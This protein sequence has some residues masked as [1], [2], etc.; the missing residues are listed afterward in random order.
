MNC[1]NRESTD[2]ARLEMIYDQGTASGSYSGGG[3]MVGHV[4]GQWGVGVS[5]QSGGTFR[6]SNLARQ[7]AP[8]SPPSNT[9]R[10]LSFVVFCVIAFPIIQGTNKLILILHQY[11][12]RDIAEY[13]EYACWGLAMI[14]ILVLPG[15]ISCL[16]V[17][18]ANRKSYQEYEKK[19]DIW[20]R[21][22]LCFR[23]GHRWYWE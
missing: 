4:G 21:T 2:I 5:T 10:C 20:R 19:F 18:L 12:H 11:L 13:A 14:C 3:T 17:E 15:I 9:S 16:L 8:P 23:C 22:W 6:Q 7:C 1:P